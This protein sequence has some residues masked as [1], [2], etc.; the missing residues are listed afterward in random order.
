MCRCSQRVANAGTWPWANRISRS[1]CDLHTLDVWCLLDIIHFMQFGH[2]DP[3]QDI[4][5]EIYKIILLNIYLEH[6]KKNKMSKD[7]IDSH[8]QLFKFQDQVQAQTGDATFILYRS[9]DQ[10]SRKTM[11]A[12]IQ[13]PL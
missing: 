7:I 4:Q 2:F 12:P 3:K 11:Q 13:S 6:G 5:V 9:S 1:I 10:A 8:W